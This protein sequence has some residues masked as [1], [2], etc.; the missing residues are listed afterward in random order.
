MTT[1]RRDGSSAR[2][3]CGF[4][5]MVSAA[6]NGYVHLAMIYTFDVDTRI[7]RFCLRAGRLQAGG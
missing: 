6:A 2:P 7:A 5:A 3:V 1:N 4:A